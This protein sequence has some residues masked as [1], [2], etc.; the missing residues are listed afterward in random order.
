MSP[1]ARAD[2]PPPLRRVGEM[3][4]RIMIVASDAKRAARRT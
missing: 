1:L 4:Y 2:R 3:G